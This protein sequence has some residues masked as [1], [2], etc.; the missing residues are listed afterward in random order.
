MDHIENIA[1]PGRIRAGA[2]GSTEHLTA[3]GYPSG[4]AKVAD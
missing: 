1:D 4:R 2:H 3:K